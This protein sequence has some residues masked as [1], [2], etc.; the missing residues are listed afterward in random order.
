MFTR[1]TMNALRAG[2]FGEAGVNATGVLMNAT[3]SALYFANYDRERLSPQQKAL[4]DS[5]HP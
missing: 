1:D 4:Y 3:G 5:M 2:R